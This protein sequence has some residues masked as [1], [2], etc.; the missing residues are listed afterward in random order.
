MDTISGGQYIDRRRVL[1]RI[2]RS[3]E[4]LASKETN[5]KWMKSPS[6]FERLVLGCID[7]S[8]RDQRLILL[9][10]SRSTRFAFLSTAQI[11]KFQPKTVQIFAEM[12]MK[13]HFSFSFFDKICDFSAKIWWNLPKRRKRKKRKNAGVSQKWSEN[14]K[15]SGDLEKKCEKNSENAR[16][17]RNFKFVRNFIFISIFQSTP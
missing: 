4:C 7:S 11:S 5:E 14:D 3:W 8:D 12:K 17:F 13:F 1:S 16:N 10:F 9:H 6:N 15:M 2:F